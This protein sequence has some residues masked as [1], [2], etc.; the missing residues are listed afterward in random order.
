MLGTHMV[1]VEVND[2]CR[3]NGTTAVTFV[4][5]VVIQ[6]RKYLKNRTRYSE[7]KNAIFLYFAKFF[8]S[9]AIIFTS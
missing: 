8:T 5:F 2:C 1:P 4:S 3:G 7:K 6:K 9:A